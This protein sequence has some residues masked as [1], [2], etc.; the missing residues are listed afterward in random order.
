MGQQSLLDSVL[1][2]LRSWEQIKA[3]SWFTLSNYLICFLLVG[4]VIASI[5]QARAKVVGLGS[6][7]LMLN[8][9][10][11]VP[12]SGSRRLREVTPFLPRPSIQHLCSLL[13]QGK[14]MQSNDFISAA[15]CPRLMRPFSSRLHPQLV[16]AI[17]R[18]LG[19]PAAALLM[20]F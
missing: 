13:L 6:L 5:L 17:Y 7:F 9:S 20:E 12:L 4:L 3:T 2:H 8:S 14:A 10:T 19:S 15:A 11:A 18:V 16:A 1:W